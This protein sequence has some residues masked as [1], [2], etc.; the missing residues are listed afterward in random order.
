MWN[1]WLKSH[2]AGAAALALTPSLQIGKPSVF[3]L[4]SNRALTR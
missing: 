4:V 2:A 3:F 1:G